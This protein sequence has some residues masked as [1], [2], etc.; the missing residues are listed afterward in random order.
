M[1]KESIVDM[2]MNLMINLAINEHIHRCK[3]CRKRLA[4]SLGC[5]LKEL[6]SEKVE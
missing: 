3:E 2:L 6:E 1:K 5:F 4:I